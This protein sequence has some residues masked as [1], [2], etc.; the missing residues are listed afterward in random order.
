METVIEVIGWSGLLGAVLGAVAALKLALLILRVLRQID[1][2]VA[3]AREGAERLLLNLA[4][5]SRV[6]AAEQAA[7]ALA[8]ES[9]MLGAAA[10]TIERELP[11]VAGPRAGT[12]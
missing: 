7:E 10:A 11:T 8:E 6:P 4:P 2:L 3:T 9:A 12:A 1:Q 5:L